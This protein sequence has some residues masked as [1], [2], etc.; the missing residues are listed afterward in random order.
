MSRRWRTTDNQGN[1]DRIASLVDIDG[2]AIH[3]LVSPHHA[4]VHCMPFSKCNGQLFHVELADDVQACLSST[5]CARLCY[6]RQRPE[7][8]LRRCTM[9]ALRDASARQLYQI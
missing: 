5:A 8:E 7:R 6:R 2:Y 4:F 1:C 9:N 3:Q